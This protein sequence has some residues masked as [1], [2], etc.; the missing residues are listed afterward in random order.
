MMRR[1]RSYPI[2]RPSGRCG[3]AAL[4]V[5]ICLSFA[6]IV[7]TLLVK[8]AV[9]EKT[10]ESRQALTHQADWLVE[11]GIY[12]A[13][14]LNLVA[15]AATR[16]KHG[17]SLPPNSMAREEPPSTLTSK[18]TPTRNSAESML[19]PNS[20]ASLEPRFEPPR[21]S[22][23]RLS[24]TSAEVEPQREGCGRGPRRLRI[25]RAFR[26]VTLFEQQR[27]VQAAVRVQVPGF[28]GFVEAGQ[29]KASRM[30]IDRPVD[31]LQLAKL[32]Q[33]DRFVWSFCF[34]EERA[35]ASHEELGVSCPATR[36]KP[37][38]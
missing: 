37:P 35:G 1:S 34:Q 22:V 19:R 15:P 23:S 16:A 9:V 33:D 3:A 7:A 32:S 31:K 2:K 12:P 8:A 25:G 10:Y 6:T 30:R 13:P 18:R 11:A 21:K 36:Q 38:R 17:R 5:L 20:K 24:A 14:P 4:F 28:R 27:G 29:K 26:Q